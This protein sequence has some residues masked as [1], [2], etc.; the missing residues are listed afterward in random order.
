MNDCDKVAEPALCKAIRQALFHL[1]DSDIPARGLLPFSAQPGVPRKKG[2][3]HLAQHY[4]AVRPARRDDLRSQMML[5]IRLTRVRLQPA[6]CFN[7]FHESEPGRREPN[8]GRRR[9]MTDDFD[10]HG[11]RHLTRTCIALT[12]LTTVIDSKV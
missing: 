12:G 10:C 11:G 3:A 1:R 9:P 2:L 5:L 4:S 6:P 8:S 7:Q